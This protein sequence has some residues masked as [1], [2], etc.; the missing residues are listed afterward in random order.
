MRL[1]YRFADGT[2]QAGK[3]EES[4]M[5]EQPNSRRLAQRRRASRTGLAF[6]MIIL[7]VGVLGA[8]ATASFSEGF[9]PPWHTFYG[10]PPSPAQIEERADRAVRHIAIEIDAT[11]EQQA[12]LQAIVKSAV[13]DL[14]PMR[15][16]VVAIRQQ[17][18][19]LLTQSTIDR[20]A[21]ERLRTEQ[22]TNVD[23]LSK[24][25]AQALADAADALT[26]DQRKKLDELLPPAGGRWRFWGHG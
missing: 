1:S 2:V 15:E 10:A 5:S 22:M 7:T 6:L 12:K 19:L 9:G 11:A 25:V 4:S 17:A 13:S 21:I 26:P 3:F 16:K 8:F 24:R 23:A 14:L 18:R 20:A